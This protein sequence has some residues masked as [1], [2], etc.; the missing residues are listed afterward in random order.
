MRLQPENAVII[1]NTRWHED[2]LSGHL[3]AMEE[4]GEYPEH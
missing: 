3:L 2:D 4:T 1:V